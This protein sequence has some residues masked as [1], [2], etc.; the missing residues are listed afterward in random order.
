MGRGVR[1]VSAASAAAATVW[2]GLWVGGGLARPCPRGAPLQPNSKA[3]VFALYTVPSFE[4]VPV[5]APASSQG[6]LP[7]SSFSVGPSTV[8]TVEGVPGAAS[9]GD[10]AIGVPALRRFTAGGLLEGDDATGV[11][12]LR[13]FTVITIGSHV[14]HWMVLWT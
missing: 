1:R 4:T 12:A 9:W 11:S 6:S 5:A 7:K 10:N 13:R 14:N 2:T 8:A 3:C